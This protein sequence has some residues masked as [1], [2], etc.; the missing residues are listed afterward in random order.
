[1]LCDLKFNVVR[2]CAGCVGKSKPDIG[3]QFFLENRVLPRVDKF[4]YLGIVLNTMRGLQADCSER[5]HKFIVI[6]S[7]VLR[8]KLLGFE[9][10]FADIF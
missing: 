6:V 8:L 1:M 5:I 4:K 7:S 2:S 3:I 10:M 9:V